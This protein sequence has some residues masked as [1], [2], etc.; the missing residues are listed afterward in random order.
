[1]LNVLIFILIFKLLAALDVL[2]I[3][4]EGIENLVKDWTWCQCH[5][6]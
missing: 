1:M 5:K 3:K 4:P 6:T 2:E